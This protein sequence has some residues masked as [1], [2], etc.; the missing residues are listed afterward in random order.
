MRNYL[1]HMV[2]HIGIHNYFFAVYLEYKFIN[3][4]VINPCANANIIIIIEIS[5]KSLKIA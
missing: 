3:Q 1:F 2:I 5:T 4:F